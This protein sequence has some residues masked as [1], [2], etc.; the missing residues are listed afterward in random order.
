MLLGKLYILYWV[1]FSRVKSGIMCTMDKKEKENGILMCVQ[2]K[3]NISMNRT[4]DRKTIYWKF[5]I[6]IENHVI[7]S[8]KKNK[9]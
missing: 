7:K 8:Q 5:S 6:E 4:V 1:V 2:C 3:E 9:I